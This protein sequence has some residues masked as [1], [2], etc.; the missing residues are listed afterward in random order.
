M[1]SIELAQKAKIQ[2]SIE[3]DE[4]SKFIHGIIN[5]KRNN[6]AIRGITV[7]GNWIEDPIKVK[8]EFLAHFKEK[9]DSPCRNR[10]LLDMIFPNK[11]STDQS[12]DLERPFS[13]EEIKGAV[14]DCGS[15]KSL[16]PDGFTF[17]F[18]LKFWS[19]LEEDVVAAVNHFFL[20]GYC[21][22]G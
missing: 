8:N 15:N 21:Q 5:K 19:L 13:T 11:L 18:Y 22:K 3:S 4:N 10:L 16:G 17:D 14:W 1:E 9:F 12:F 6:L 2:W 20:H 7:D